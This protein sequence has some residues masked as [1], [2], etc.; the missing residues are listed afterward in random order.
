MDL[1]EDG[2]EIEV[3]TIAVD[4][5]LVGSGLR[6]VG[7][8]LS[9]ELVEVDLDAGTATTYGL[10]GVPPDYVASLAIGDD[11]VVLPTY[12]GGEPFVVR[13]DGTVTRAAVQMDGNPILSSV[14]TETFWR[15][16]P[17]FDVGRMTV[18]EVD[19]DG[20]PTGVEFELPV[21]SWPAMTDPAGGVVVQSSGRW[22]SIDPDGAEA[23]GVGE[24]VALDETLALLFDCPELD[25]CG[26]FR[27][28]RAT[29]ETVRTPVDVSGG[30]RFLPT[31]WQSADPSSGVSPD[32]RIVAV[33]VDDGTGSGGLAVIDLESGAITDVEVRGG[34]PP[35]P[36][37]SPNGEFIVFVDGG[38]VPTA[39]ELASGE[40][41]PVDPDGSL[42]GWGNIGRRP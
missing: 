31:A 16:S 37:W 27:R 3:E 35:L 39:Y 41:F 14:N 24:L 13:T 11:W 30:E 21:N 40:T 7:S 38:G 8:R 15:M 12:N 4:P 28:D 23:I 36:V 5:R 10:D 33:G 6:I 32:G 42:T 9:D 25:E 22:F 2:A 19:L 26:L 18:R 34:G 29:G 1:V 17:I 20:E